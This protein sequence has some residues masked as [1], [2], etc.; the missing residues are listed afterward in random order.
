[1]KN[2]SGSH[3]RLSIMLPSLLLSLLG[4]LGVIIALYYTHSKHIEQGVSSAIT[5]VDHLYR[6]SLEEDT[7]K[8]DVALLFLKDNEAIQK[9]WIQRDRKGL[10][11]LCS[12]TFEFLKLNQRITHL[13]FIDLDR[14]V[15]LRVHNQDKNG[16][17]LTRHTI[18]EA[19]QTG[20]RSVGVEFGIHHNFT[21]RNVHPWFINGELSGFIEM[22]E[23][24]DHILPRVTDILD[25]EVFV[26][27]NKKL[28]SKEK[29]EKGVT[30]Y[31]HDTRWDILDESVLIGKTMDYIPRELDRHLNRQD[32]TGGSLFSIREEGKHYIGGFID[33]K[34][35]QE[36]KVGKLVVLKDVT[37]LRKAV[38]E[39]IVFIVVVGMLLFLLIMTIIFTHVNRI[40]GQLEFYHSKLKDAAHTDALTEIGNRR[41]LV[42]QAKLFLATS[43]T[44]AVFLIDIDHFKKV[45]DIYGHDV[46]DEVLRAVSR[47]ISKT[48]RQDDI[49]ARYGG[50]EFA[51]LLSGCPLETALVKAEAIRL[52]VDSLVVAA[53]AE[54]VHVTVSIG[55]YEIQQGDSF[56]KL[57]ARVD[58]A[59]Y[60]A[61]TNGRNRIE[62]YKPVA[63]V[64]SS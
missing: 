20:N 54:T 48:L 18:A 16:D 8:M 43:Q 5:K 31:G 45:N 1:M 60:Q 33:L 22:G 27:F 53:Q 11:G 26:T 28:F 14:R 34:N 52:A 42:E 58:G 15:F 49:F 13:Y 62:I 55:I 10:Y 51:V 56:E 30:L 4:L 47:T 25:T 61:K 57:L 21:L 50:E 39:Q 2:L 29:W 9:A 40:S 12:P 23:E 63:G 41:Y 17:V 38:K 64:L 19:Q 59:M 36:T 6:T 37:A 7:Q 35:V 24:I 3:I 44:G 32:D 46:G